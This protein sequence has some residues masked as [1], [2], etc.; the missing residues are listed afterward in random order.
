[1]LKV[2]I[3]MAL[4][5]SLLGMIVGMVV[6]FRGGFQPV[7]A[8]LIE[9]RMGVILEM[10]EEVETAAHPMKRL[11]RIGRNLG[12]KMKMVRDPRKHRRFIP[13]EMSREGRTIYLLKGKGTPMGIE[14]SIDRPKRWLIVHFPAHLEDSRQRVFFGLLLLTIFGVVGAFALGRWSLKPL[15]TAAEAM[16]RIA[17]GDLGHRVSDPI[18]PAGV[19][20]NAMA[21][22]LERTIGGQKDFMAAMGHELRTPIARLKLQL[23]LMENE[24]RADSLRGDVEELEDL[25]ES[26]LETSRLE[27]GGIVLHL[28]AVQ[29][30]TL[31]LELLAEIDIGD[32]EVIFEVQ[33]DLQMH[34]DRRWFRL[35]VRNLLSNITRYTPEDVSIWMGAHREGTETMLWVADSGEGVE[36]SFLTQMFDPFVRA[37]KSRNKI[38][39]GLGLGL[40]LVR[41]VAELHNGYV[42]AKSNPRTETGLEIVIYIPQKQQSII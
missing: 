8:K 11:R 41:Q 31:F 32:R 37:E 42:Q 39:G 30:R 12:V 14:L 20:F 1:M 7:K 10:A 17:K 21:E 19:S 26:L 22:R 35:V 36:E 16:D 27:R 28:E 4:I 24:K 33:E 13:K 6:L 38:T 3:Y 34:I 15:E 5:L 18:G 25:V 23:E 2:R 29:I 9:E 40:M